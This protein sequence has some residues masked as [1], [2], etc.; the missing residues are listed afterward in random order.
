MRANLD[1]D[2]LLQIILVLIVV[3]LVLEVLEATVDLIGSFFG[4][5]PN[6][7]GLAIVVL[8]VLWLLDRI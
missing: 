5:L 4:L 8:I 7:I 3:W 6:L 2:T 1:A